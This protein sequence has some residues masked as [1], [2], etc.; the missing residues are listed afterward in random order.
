MI[1]FPI[2]RIS[3]RASI[4]NTLVYHRNN[5]ALLLIETLYLMIANILSCGSSIDLHFR[6]RVPNEHKFQ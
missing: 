6:F 2:R 1:E 3:T 5:G 4:T